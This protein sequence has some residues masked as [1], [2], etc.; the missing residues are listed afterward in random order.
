MN[1]SRGNTRTEDGDFR[2]RLSWYYSG[3]LNGTNPKEELQNVTETAGNDP[4]YP[5][6]RSE[7][8]CLRWKGNTAYGPDL[9]PIEVWKRWEN[10]GLYFSGTKL[11]E[12]I[13]TGIPYS[14]GLSEVTPLFKGKGSILGYSNNTG[15]QRISFTL[16]LL[17]R[18]VNQLLRTI[19]ELG[20]I[21]FGFRR[22]RSNMDPVFALKILQEKYKVK[23]NEVHVIFVDLEKA[24][25]IHVVPR[26][27]LWWA[28]R[29]R[30]I[31]EWYVKVIQDMYRGP[32]T[33]VRS[34]LLFTIIMDVL[35]EEARTK[36]P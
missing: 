6:R 31:P 2:N 36:P 33:N 5:E 29:T 1:D 15:I 8:S 19:V 3:L 28:M 17:E 32:K 7:I 14:W 35:A 11:N 27:L 18:M 21:Q 20:N 12:V 13:V 26:H 4:R 25:D 30:A 23:Q 9:I 24:Y 10:K 16:K 34:P 22:G